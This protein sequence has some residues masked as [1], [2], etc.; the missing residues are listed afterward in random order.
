MTDW[1]G[2]SDAVAQMK[3]GND[4]LM[5]GTIDQYNAIV[6]AVKNGTLDEKILNENVERMLQLVLE[7]PTYK[8]Y[9]YSEKPDLKKNA[10]L[11]PFSSNRGY[12]FI[13]E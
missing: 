1:G 10:Q 8:G 3:A 7:S 5:P 2:G 13:K 12:G 11:S 6:N 9:K 4:L